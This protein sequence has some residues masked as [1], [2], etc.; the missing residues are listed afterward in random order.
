[1]QGPIDHSRKRLRRFLLLFTL[2]IRRGKPLSAP[3]LSSFRKRIVAPLLPS[4]HSKPSAWAQLTFS[5]LVHPLLPPPKGSV[6]SQATVAARGAQGD[7]AQ[8][9]A[10]AAYAALV[11]SPSMT[12]PLDR[13]IDRLAN[14]FAAAVIKALKPELRALLE[15]EIEDLKARLTPAIGF[16]VGIFRQPPN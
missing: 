1:M 12:N 11:A 3:G 7:A 14:R 8:W 2:E 13:L 10:A 6:A 15:D 4:H 16:P 5:L 9:A